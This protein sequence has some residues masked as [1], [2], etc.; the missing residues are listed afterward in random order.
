MWKQR[1]QIV[2][3]SLKRVNKNLE[4]E[5]EDVPE[6]EHEQGVG[7]ETLGQDAA[8]LED[9]HLEPHKEETK[10]WD[11]GGQRLL[12]FLLQCSKSTLNCSIVRSDIALEALE[13]SSTH[14]L[15]I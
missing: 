9:K 6:E 14:I 10:A 15:S 5:L 11:A 3:N 13:A 7:G 2:E 12:I 8:T 4:G 1:W